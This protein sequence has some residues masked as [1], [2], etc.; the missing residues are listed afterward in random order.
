[1]WVINLAISEDVASQVN[2]LEGLDTDTSD[3]DEDKDIE[4]AS[5]NDCLHC[6]CTHNCEFA[7]KSSCYNYFMFCSIAM[8]FLRVH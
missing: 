8:L 2:L 7:M 4:L 1:M 3:T 6:A 5:C